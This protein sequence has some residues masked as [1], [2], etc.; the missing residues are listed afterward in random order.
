MLGWMRLPFRFL[1]RHPG[2]ALLS[3][4]LLIAAL[5][6]LVN[7]WALQ[8]FRAAEQALHDDQ[9][10]PARYHISECLRV[11]QHGPATH[12]L[13]ARIE[14]IS[15]RYP[16]AEQHLRECV[17]LQHEVS[18][19][20]QL[21]E[22]LIRAQ[23]GDL[24]EVEAG[25][26]KLIET[27]HPESPQIL[28]TLARIYVREGR[29]A[30]AQACLDRWVKREPQSA[31]A[32][33]WRGWVHEQSRNPVRA[34][35]D[36]QQALELEPGRWGARLRLTGLLLEWNNLNQARGNIQELERTHPDDPGV[37]AAL[38]RYQELNGEGE[39]AIR[40]LDQ[41]L[42]T[43]PDYFEALLLRGQLANQQQQPAE[44]EVY[45]RRALRLH[46]ANVG[47]LYALFQCLEQQ[48]K[49]SESAKIYNRYKEAQ[50]DA[51]RLAQL[52][53][54]NKGQLPEDANVLS[55]V[56][57]LC[58]RLDE[59]KAGL[60]WLYRA[61]RADPNHKPTHE[62]LLRYYESKG[63]TQHAEE[64]RRRLAQLGQR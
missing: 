7:G 23:S 52:V 20:T 56:G 30:A 19:A 44:G 38:A 45:L 59:E 51:R 58:L 10:D 22:I 62:I 18:E 31:R 25:L 27:D 55:E 4:L 42:Q 26:W 12:F 21:E 57:A 32:W 9:M 33:H 3:V 60:S 35:L 8:Q 49:E 63:D 36:Y 1:R 29:F 17:R 46:P 5:V 41:V 24:A 61:L 47:V 39:Q 50:A 37:Q 28:E 48:G 54:P 6:G 34:M 11:W 64:H 14:R 40:L 43:H 2:V 53:N 13:A 16:E 15:G